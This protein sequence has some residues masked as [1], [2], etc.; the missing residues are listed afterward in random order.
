LPIRGG[1]DKISTTCGR[2]NLM[3]GKAMR[4][5]LLVVVMVGGVGCK[6]RK[7]EAEQEGPADIAP[8][9]KIVAQQTVR[10][11]RPQPTMPKKGDGSEA[12]VPPAKGEAKSPVP[13]P[14]ETKKEP[15]KPKPSPEDLLEEID[16]ERIAKLGTRFALL[17][18]ADQ[19]A[20]ETARSKI[21]KIQRL[22]EADF[23]AAKEHPEFFTTAE[24]NHTW[25]MVAESWG[26][27]SLAVSLGLNDDQTKRF[28]IMLGKDPER[29]A[30]SFAIRRARATGF[31]SLAE[32]ERPL[33]IKYVEFLENC[34]K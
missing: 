6:G 4:S 18:H 26:G 16:R 7:S 12:A 9:K 3:E 11:P 1:F 13:K 28:K 14:P 24:L 17:S 19:S 21:A 25:T 34:P 33:L 31:K 10:N 22:D 5:L 29:V 27:S 2:I 23:I 15:P 8:A 32:S 30:V 20:I